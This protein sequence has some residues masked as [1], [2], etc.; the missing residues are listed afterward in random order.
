MH[1]AKSFEV[2]AII[3]LLIGLQLKSISQ[4]TAKSPLTEEQVLALV[5]SSQLG[6]VDVNRVVELIQERG[7]GFSVT[8]LFLLELGARGADDAIVETLRAL[9]K[10][11]RDAFEGTA[12]EDEPHV[13]PPVAPPQTSEAQDGIGEVSEDNFPQFLESV[14]ATALAYTDNLPNFI[15]TQITQ[16]FI[17][18][19][20]GGWRQVDNYVADL[21]YF[22]KKENYK[23]ISVANQIVAGDTTM[24]SLKGTRSTGEFGSA[25]RALFDPE[26]KATFRL[27]GLDE[28]NGHKTARLGY[29]VPKET[30][31][32]TIN[33]NDQRTIITGYRGR[34]WIDPTSFNI[35]RLEDK[36]VGIPEDFPITRSEGAVDYDLAEISGRQYW[37]P[38]RAEILL[39]EGSRRFHSRNVIEFK[40]YRKFEAEVRLVPD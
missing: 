1:R 10:Q 37:L 28:T 14:R 26:T 3:L 18:L 2:V 29:Q 11:G 17:R 4:E 27:E 33:Y 21:T 12:H 16:R 30:S 15:C 7:I 34:C 31:S 35:V 6:E 9:R 5:T 38:V 19:F 8:D 32:R 20:P 40:R 25:L 22:E 39:I 24:Q 13:S 23:I 36:A